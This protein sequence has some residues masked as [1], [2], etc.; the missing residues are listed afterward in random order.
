MTRSFTRKERVQIEK[1]TF[2]AQCDKCKWPFGIF[3][4]NQTATSI[5]FAQFLEKISFENSF[6]LIQNLNPT[7][8]RQK[9]YFNI[10]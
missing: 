8:M 6:S 10:N 2:A 3:L 9:F 4:T 7:L 1:K 5:N